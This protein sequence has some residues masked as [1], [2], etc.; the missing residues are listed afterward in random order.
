MSSG[1]PKSATSWPQSS[2]VERARSAI[3]RGDLLSAY[4]LA[5]QEGGLGASTELSYIAVLAMARMGET[6]QAMRLYEQSGLSTQPMSTASRWGARPLK[7]HALQD[8]GTYHGLKRAA[9]AYADAYMRSQDPFPA[10]NAA[11]LNLLAGDQERGRFFAQ[12]ALDAPHRSPPP[13]TITAPP[14]GPKR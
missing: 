11:T 8:G 7:D 9:E 14:P 5:R 10:I 6:Q 13:Q 2:L 3:G 12:I 1:I 4:D